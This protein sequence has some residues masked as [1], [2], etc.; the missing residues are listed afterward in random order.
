MAKKFKYS[1]ED[2]KSALAD[3]NSKVLSLNKAAAQYGIPKS[4]LSM[5]LSGKSPPNRKMGPSSF[6]TV[7]EENK[8]KSWILNNAKLGFP[9]RTDD[10]KDSVQKVIIDFPRHVPFK[11]SRPGDKWMK[12]FL[13]RNPEIAK[14]NT[15]VISKARAAVTEDKIRNWFQELDTYLVSEGSRNVLNDATRIFNCDETG[16]QTCPKSGR[17]LGPK[18]LKDFY[19]IEPGKEKECI[20]VLCT[21]G[22]DGSIPPPMVIYPYKRLPSSI[23]T[24]FPEEWIIGRSDSGWMVS[25]TFYE[26]ISNGFIHGYLMRKSNFL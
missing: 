19:E 22:A 23:M 7:E 4:T 15:E 16:L 25:N 21:Y 9:L 5:K 13:K 26:Y 6:L 1:E 20:T 17:V 11:N 14:R 10:V 12:L 2:M 8:I 24:T 18:S 3:I